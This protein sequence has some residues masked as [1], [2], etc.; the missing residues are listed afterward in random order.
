MTVW[1]AT[2]LK[3]HIDLTVTLESVSGETLF[4][5]ANET[6]VRIATR[7][8]TTAATVVVKTLVDAFINISINNTAVADYYGKKRQNRTTFRK[9]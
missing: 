6:V 2:L 9:L 7:S 8:V 1:N 3:R 4:A 5:L